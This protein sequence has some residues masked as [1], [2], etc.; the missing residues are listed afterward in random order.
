MSCC[1][2]ELWEA[3]LVSVNALSVLLW[4]LVSLSRL[5]ELIQSVSD[6]FGRKKVLLATMTGNILS[7]LVW[8]RSTTFVRDSLFYEL[9]T[10]LFSPLSSYRRVE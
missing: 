8:L 10:G 5:N 9:T 4:A 1:S 3:C 6:R 2:V 7:A